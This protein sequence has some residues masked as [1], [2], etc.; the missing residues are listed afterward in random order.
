MLASASTLILFAGAANGQTAATAIFTDYGGFWSTS[1]TANSATKPDNSH[2]LL[3]FVSNSDTF[4]TGVNNS[5]L[6]T[7]GVT[8]FVPTQ[9]QAFS[10][11]GGVF[12]PSSSTVIGVGFEYG[13]TGNVNPLPV[14]NNLPLYMTDGVQGLNLGTAVFNIPTTN[15]LYS[16]SGLS[17]TAAGDGVPDLIIT[18]VG[19]P[20]ASGSLDSFRFVDAGGATVGNAVPISLSGV[21]ILGQGKWKFYDP[22]NPPTYNAGLAGD[23]PLRLVAFDLD[24]FGLN[25]GNIGTVTGFIHKLSGNSDQA[26]TAYNTASFNVSPGSAL[27]VSLTSF[28][29]RADQDD[30]LLHWTVASVS[31]IARF[32]IERSNDGRSYSDLGFVPV[33]DQPEY[34]FRDE[35]PARGLN[36]YRLKMVEENGNTSYSA[37]QQLYFQ[38]RGNSIGLFPNPAD[39]RLNINTTALPATVKEVRIYDLSG[40]QVLAQIVSG[41]TF[42]LDI[43][44]LAAGHYLLHLLDDKGQILARQSFSKKQ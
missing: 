9:F 16:V 4:S 13:G 43:R 38:G 2:T 5:L 33:T 29:A 19:Q 37:V 7:N 28:S 25:A 11:A 32:R 12:N 27:P 44:A 36:Y 41:S 22:V 10:L 3:A 23:R 15:V 30:A 39:G 24:D 20:P 42:S 18:Q 31:G 17:A 8:S 14:S 26:F 40:R 21:N 1:T 34:L 35:A 6:T